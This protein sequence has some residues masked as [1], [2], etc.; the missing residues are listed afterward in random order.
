[1]EIL[2]RRRRLKLRLSFE[3]LIVGIF[4]GIIIAAFRFLIDEADIYRPIYFE[5]LKLKQEVHLYFLT[6]IV[7]MLIAFILTKFIKID[8]QIA[9]SGVPQI[10][11]I[12]QDKM[13]MTRPLRLVLMKFIASTA[14]IGAGMSLGR[15][16]LSVQFG[17]CIGNFFNKLLGRHHIHIS[18]SETIESK[19]LLTAGAGA[20]LAA[21]FNA[22]LS[23]VIFCVEELQKKFS[24]EL[25]MVSM[26]SAVSASTI[27]KFVFGIRPVFET[28]TPSLNTVPLISTAP[29]TE[30]LESMT[31]IK[32][33]ICLIVLG[34][35]VGILGS[36]FTKILIIS[37][38]LYDKLN[39]LG[40][41][42]FMVPLILILP[43]G[44][45]LPDILGCGNILVDELLSHHFLLFTLIILYIS[46]FLFTMICF[47]TNAPGGIFLPLLVL[48]ALSGNIFASI[49]VENN[50]FG[51]EWTAM[52]IIFAMAAYFAAVVKSPITGSV[53]IMELTGN[54]YH[55][56]ALIIVSSIAFLVSDLCGGK[57]AYSALLE[58]SLNRKS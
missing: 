40:V 6:L 17:A 55:L 12:L 28:I 41:K 14:C 56:L 45:T 3:G 5:L 58:R 53:L 9:G 11:G 13:N 7:L 54:F 18:T 31:P 44:L 37:L 34:S 48:G 51:V 30:M 15:A 16:G 47:G 46:K 52:F 36:M 23:G 39:I 2:T 21:I 43:I 1:M 4:T 24:P 32:F 42:R 27:V 49:G 35:F 33:F 20:G 22:P 10:K 26:T 38:D 19:Y 29:S 57:P 25:L 50:F 8:G